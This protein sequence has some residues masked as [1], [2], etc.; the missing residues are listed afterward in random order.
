MMSTGSV[1]CIV[2]THRRD[3]ALARALASIV[4]QRHTP[5]VVV[6]VD[7]VASPDTRQLTREQTGHPDITYVDNSGTQRPGA[8]SSRNAGA[9]LASSEYLA[10]LDDDDRWEAGFLEQCVA[11]L[12]L[13]DVD[14]VTVAG[15]VEIGAERTRRPWLGSRPVTARD[16]LAWNPGVTGSNFVIRRT[17]FEDIGGFDDSLPV[18]ND[19]DF[20]VRYLQSGRH[21]AVVD[22]EL[23]IQT[24]E[25]DDHLSSRSA[26]RAAG[27]QKYISK[28]SSQLNAGQLRALKREVHLA[29]RYVGQRQ[30]LAAYHFVL[31]W[32]NSS[33]AQFLTVLRRKLAGGRKMYV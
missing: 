9:V 29:Q 32:V 15:A 26:R 33:P 6:V 1:T 27:I 2:P 11:R 13:G 25:G 7:D 19:L 10:F 28:H 17:A 30:H 3:A 16:C 21:Y 14:L 18:F 31:M 24:A 20:F 12:E 22:E 5:A 23:F 4:E 8:S